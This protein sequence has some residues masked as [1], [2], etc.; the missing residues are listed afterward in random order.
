[1]TIDE[2]FQDHAELGKTFNLV[3][4]NNDNTIKK[5]NQMKGIYKLHPDANVHFFSFD[6]HYLYFHPK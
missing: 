5:W 3:S 1:M 6:N 2:A 4:Y